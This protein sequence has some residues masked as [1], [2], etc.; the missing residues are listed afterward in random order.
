[1]EGL[2]HLPRRWLMPSPRRSCCR[3]R[4]HCRPQCRKCLDLSPGAGTGRRPAY[5]R[6]AKV[7]NLLQQVAYLQK[8]VRRLN[9]IWEAEKKLDSW[10]QAQPAVDS[11]PTAKQPPLAQT[12]EMGTNNAEEWK[13][14]MAGVGRRKRLPLKPKVPLQNHFTTLQIEEKRPSTSEEML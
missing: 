1:M 9:N 3:E 7:E 14:A 2:Q 8:A 13:L 11:Q 6:S 12:E 5:R 4:L 10:F